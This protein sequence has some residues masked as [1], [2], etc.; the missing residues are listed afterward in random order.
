MK[1]LIA[2]ALVFICSFAS[3]QGKYRWGQYPVN[4]NPADYTIK[5]HISATHFRDCAVLAVN[6]YCGEGLYADATVDGKNFEIFGGVDKR[7][8][9]L[10][11]PGDYLAMLPRKPR[12]GG[13]AVVGQGYYM[14]LPN[15]SAW[16]CSIT[17]LSE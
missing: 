10:I 1:R 7:Q 2:L 17:G 14:L 13:N 5:V 12:H 4:Q 15:R 3:A 8:A 16:I 6:T 11:V 9:S